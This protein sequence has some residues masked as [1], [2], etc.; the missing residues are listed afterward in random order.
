MRHKYRTET[1]CL[2]PPHFS[3]FSQAELYPSSLIPLPPHSA[4]SHAVVGAGDC[5]QSVSVPL[6]HYFLFAPFPCSWWGPS[7]G[8][9]DRPS[10]SWILPRSYSFSA[11]PGAHRAISYTSSLLDSILPFFTWAFPEMPPSNK[12]MNTKK[13]MFIKALVY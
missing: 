7:M 8:L 1:T 10:P 2:L 3:P 5:G 12:L 4:L 13:L 9:Q 11:H 6:C